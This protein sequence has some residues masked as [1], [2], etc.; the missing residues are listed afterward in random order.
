MC[1]IKL[2]KFQNCTNLP[3]PFSQ[4]V[5]TA[6]AATWVSVFAIIPQ[7]CD[8]R[9]MHDEMIAI[10][11]ALHFLVPCRRAHI[12]HSHRC[13]F[14]GRDS[15]SRVFSSF[16]FCRVSSWR[17]A[18]CTKMLFVGRRYIEA[19]AR[20]HTKGLKKKKLQCAI[21][22]SI[23]R[24]WKK[25]NSWWKK[26]ENAFNKINSIYHLRDL[27]FPWTTKFMLYMKDSCVCTLRLSM[28]M[29]L[30]GWLA[31][32]KVQ[33]APHSRSAVCDVSNMRRERDEAAECVFSR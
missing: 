6:K 14:Q 3:L 8:K 2:R 23:E 13:S 31:A 15:L 1:Q 16:C 7:L 27:K 24:R 12:I 28:Y 25:K 18:Y 26:S 22:D 11:H 32:T 10:G 20:S 30:I 17:V 33:S 19:R 29:C 5:P 9:F 21:K 4:Q